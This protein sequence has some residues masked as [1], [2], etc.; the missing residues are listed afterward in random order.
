MENGKWKNIEPFFLNSDSFSVGHSFVTADGKK[1][2]FISDMPGG[3]GGT[4]IYV[5]ERE[6]DKWGTPKNLGANI[7]TF[8]KESHDTIVNL[9]A[10]FSQ[11]QNHLISIHPVH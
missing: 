9:Q 1:M 4:D 3:F 5:S 11:R 7:N 2:Y 8:A 6:N 10:K